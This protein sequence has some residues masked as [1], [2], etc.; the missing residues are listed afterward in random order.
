MVSFFAKS[1]L[2]GHPDLEGLQSS[3]YQWLLE[4][5]QEEVAGELRAKEGDL[6]GAVTLYMKAG[7]PAKAARLVSQHPELAAQ[8][9]LLQHIASALLKTGLHEKAGELFE[10]ARSHKEAMEAYR[11]GRAFRRAVELARVAFPGEVVGLEEQWGNEL[12]RQKQ[13]D[14]AITHYIEAG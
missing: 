11:S 14:A 10:Q 9:D 13:F 12:C 2:Q 1:H 4:S 6:A 8:A 5:G 3:Y 7:L